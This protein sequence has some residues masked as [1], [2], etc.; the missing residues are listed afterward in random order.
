M[1]K[2]HLNILKIGY[3]ILI[4]LFFKNGKKYGHLRSLLDINNFMNI[5]PN[6]TI[7]GFLF[8][9]TMNIYDIQQFLKIPK[10]DDFIAATEKTTNL[11]PKIAFFQFFFKYIFNITF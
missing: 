2:F 1:S 9:Q 10:I 4:L 8:V 5:Q 7:F 3:F 6:F 11:G